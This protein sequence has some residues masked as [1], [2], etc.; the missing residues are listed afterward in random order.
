MKK[1]LIVLLV[2]ACIAGGIYFA[3]T[4]RKADEATSPAT[5]SVAAVPTKEATTASTKTA[6][7]ATPTAK[8]TTAATK[9]AATA[10]PKPVQVT[11]TP[12]PTPEPT[13][14]LVTEPRLLG[15]DGDGFLYWQLPDGTV[16]KLEPPEESQVEA[17]PERTAEPTPTPEPARVYPYFFVKIGENMVI[18]MEGAP[19]LDHALRSE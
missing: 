11:A 15:K 2:I 8:A 6:A 9:T 10:T 18:P 4:Q 14:E 19:L 5:Q 3:V 7:T 17:T 16:L 13:P 12:T 1:F